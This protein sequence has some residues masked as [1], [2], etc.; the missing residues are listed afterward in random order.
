M[1]CNA[2]Q[3]MTNKFREQQFLNLKKKS[4]GFYWIFYFLLVQKSLL[5]EFVSRILLSIALDAF[6]N[7]LTILSP[8]YNFASFGAQRVHS[9]QIIVDLSR[10]AAA[11]NFGVIN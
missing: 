4:A 9:V 5:P 2:Q 7:F 11:T 8:C 1:L 10:P 6:T 3:H